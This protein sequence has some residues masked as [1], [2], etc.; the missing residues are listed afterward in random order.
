MQLSAGNRAFQVALWCAL[1]QKLQK[2]KMHLNNRKLPGAALRLSATRS[3]GCSCRYA[4][5]ALD[6]AVS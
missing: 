6:L 5:P 4:T 3:R 1:S 2:R